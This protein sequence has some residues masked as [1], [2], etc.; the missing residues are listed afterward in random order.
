ME[1]NGE[2]R[3]EGGGGVREAAYAVPSPSATVIG[4][5]N[6]LFRSRYVVVSV[7]I[8]TALLVS[9]KTLIVPRSYTATASFA[10][11]MVELPRSGIAGL[12]AQFGFRLGDQIPGQSPEFYAELLESDAIL[13]EAVETQYTIGRE[14]A[15]DVSLAGEPVN[16]TLLRFF[17]VE[18]PTYERR[19][20]KAVEELRDAL[21]VDVHTRTGIVA[22]AVQTPWPQLSVG[23]ANRLLELVDEFN[24]VTRQA[25]AAAERRFTEE[26]LTQSRGELRE[27]EERLQGFLQGNRTWESSPELR[28]EHDRLERDVV[29]RQEVYTSLMQAYEQARIDEV[30]NTPLITL[31]ESPRLPAEPDP[32][33]LVL[34][35]ALALL[36]GGL[37]GVGIALVR[38]VFRRGRQEAV[39]EFAEFAALRRAAREDLESLW[40]GVKGLVAR[41]N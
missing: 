10:Q 4:L 15:G 21:R 38:D 19:V 22:L 1:G 18:Q 31:I 16:G 32:R 24:T 7:P 36:L 34:K 27:A 23:I 14:N 2:M 13:R 3:S 40:R 26:R 9:V 17:Q 41:G 25:Q 20:A 5:M 12:A 39:D 11:Q 37:L 30:R 28:F 8:A 35:A 33:L 29:M 6:L